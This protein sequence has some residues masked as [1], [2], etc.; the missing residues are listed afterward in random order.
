M[1]IVKNLSLIAFCILFALSGAANAE[2][3]EFIAETGF[4]NKEDKIVK[5][6]FFEGEKKIILLGEKKLQIWDYENGKL[7]DS[8]AHGIPKFESFKFFDNVA[9]FGVPP[10]ISWE[11]ILIDPQGKWIVT[12][13][14]SAD[15]KKKTAIVRDVPAMKQ[16]AALELPDNS[17]DFVSYD[18]NRDEIFVIGIDDNDAA[19][20]NWKRDSFEL[21]QI[22][23]VAEYKWHQFVKNGEK[24][25][26]GSGDSKT[27]W[28]GYNLKQGDSLTLRDAKTGAI[29]KEFTAPNFQPRTPF[30]NTLV[31]KDEK[32]LISVRDDR[33]LIWDI[34][35]SGQP[36][37]EL[38]D[39]DTNNDFGIQSLLQ[40]RFFFA[41]RG[42][43]IYVYDVRGDNQPKYHFTAAAP[44][45]SVRIASVSGDEQYAAVLQDEKISVLKVDSNGKPLY[46]IVR[47]SPNERFNAVDITNLHDF[48]VVT[49]NNK[50]DKKPDRTEV[51]DLKT[52]KIVEV[53]PENVGNGLKVT[54][55]GN[56][57]YSVNTGYVYVWNFEKKQSYKISLETYTNDCNIGG[58][59]TQ[60][61]CIETT[62][63][64]EHI[65]L[66]PNEKFVLRYGEEIVSVFDIETGKEIQ[67]I[68]NPK[69]AKYN[70]F[71]KLK[72]SGIGTAFWSPDGKFVYAYDSYGIF[73]NNR[74]IS[75]WRVEN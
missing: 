8:V 29:E 41:Y 70:K 23:S 64:A 40:D 39:A 65:A 72:N 36:R 62:Q 22:I 16:L 66:S 6:Q 20:A 52:G 67:Q 45:D 57:L 10:A 25:I 21:R 42:K 30:R 63:N 61:G 3:L 13:E 11:S 58:G 54:T 2:L 19:I 12:I 53:I 71:N 26:I 27:S 14:P 69:R 73:F 15:K 4:E 1:R 9:Y 50:K 46:E 28:S 74:K 32:L 18:P 51:Y 7:L 33:I 38:S 68:L 17:A 60:P 37:L 59:M 48:L 49:R 44:N 47:D 43:D 55:D 75:F 24:I 5:Y 34:D 35:G 31:T 56:F